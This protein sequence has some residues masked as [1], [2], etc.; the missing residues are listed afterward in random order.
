MNSSNIFIIQVSKF[1]HSHYLVNALCAILSFLFCAWMN[2]NR[3]D[4]RTRSF[5]KSAWTKNTF[6][7]WLAPSLAKK[8]L[9]SRQVMQYNLKFLD[10]IYF[11]VLFIY[12]CYTNLF[13]IK[14]YFCVFCSF[15]TSSLWILNE[16]LEIW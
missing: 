1:D 11:Y 4:S 3:N 6:D 9:T 13:I 12:S 8:K 14:S 10:Q 5:V 7:V 15:F 16:P 2:D